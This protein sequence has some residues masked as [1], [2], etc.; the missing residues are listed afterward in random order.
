MLFIISFCV[1]VVFLGGLSS[2]GKLKHG[3][4]YAFFFIIVFSAF[5]YNYGNDYPA[6]QSAFRE[7][8]KI[9]DLSSLL[10]LFDSPFGKY[11]GSEMGWV[12]LNWFFKPIGF[13]GMIIFTSILTNVIY[14][15]FIKTYVPQKWYWLALFT[16]IFNTSL[17]FVPLSMMRQSL[18]MALFV[19]AFKYISDRKVVISL[20][21]IL[22]AV[23]VHKSALVLLP[24]T[25]LGF[26][27][28]LN[29][30]YISIGFVS[31]FLLVLMNNDVAS[32]VVNTALALEAFDSY[33]NYFD[34]MEEGKAFGLGFVASLLTYFVPV[35]FYL[36]DSTHNSNSNRLLALLA[37]VPFVIAPFT[38]VL[39]FLGRIG[40]YFSIFSIVAVPILYQWVRNNMLR[41]G[42]IALYI[43]YTLYSYQEFFA[44]STWKSFTH[45]QTIFS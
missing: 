7:I 21:L 31:L 3:L 26:L 44:M 29:G 13:K 37:A 41:Y 27:S 4:E 23:C 35:L 40:Y 12:L 9:P 2:L 8:A 6:Y 10:K 22:L 33:D 42:L 45:Y 43:A 39:G 19:F 5:R 30:K 25:L 1:F 16:Y 36:A 24:F 34:I 14:Y 11:E 18:G 38:L 17:F 32:E 20:L 15:K 28:N